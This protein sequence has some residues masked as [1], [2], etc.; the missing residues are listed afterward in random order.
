M[1]RSER[2]AHY[3]RIA[4][5]QRV[6]SQALRKRIYVFGSLRLALFLTV[7]AAAYMLYHTSWALFAALIVGAVLFAQLLSRQRKLSR[8]KS[9]ADALVKI[10]EN[11]LKAFN[12]DYSA[13]DGAAERV[14][15]AHDFSFDLDIFGE[16]SVFQLM[17]R[18]ALSMGKE[19]LADFLEHP[20]HESHPIA[21]RQEAVKELAELEDF[22]LDF[23]K[24]G[25]QTSGGFSRLQDVSDTFSAQAVF[26]NRIF[27]Q[28]AL[29]V[30]PLVYV[31][32]LIFSFIG[33]VPGNAFIILYFATLGLSS[34]PIKRISRIL[35]TFNKKTRR[36]ENYAQLYH[37]IENTSFRSDSLQKWQR[38][39]S[40]PM[41]ASKAIA[42]LDY[43]CRNLDVVF[44]PALFI[45]NPL[46]LFN[47]RYAL[48]ID[49][50]TR[51]H[52][53]QTRKWFDAL[54]EFDA[55]VSLGTF[56]A[57]NPDFAFPEISDHFVFIGKKM[58]HPLLSREKCVKNDIEIA[59]KPYFLIVTGANMAGKSTYLRTIGVNHLLASIGAP[60]YAE[61]LRFY[62]GR[63]LSNLRTADSLVNSE[64]YFFAEL[65]RLKMI[66]D[67][68]QSD[69]E[70]GLF[71][72]LDEILKGTNSED[73]QKGSF[74]LMRR[75]V[76]L[77]GNG[78]IATHDL[79]LGA[80]ETEFPQAI[81]NYH[82]D[83]GISNDTLSFTYL[84]HEGVARNMNA[85]FL[86]KN[87]GI[88]E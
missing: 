88:V 23:R 52:A 39:V 28:V 46:L 69:E 72:I 12:G 74:A 18:T 30:V 77:G 43:Y 5:E 35:N 51:R 42:K 83:A 68:L 53:D 32:L 40:Q 54:A 62:P 47:V 55:L 8:K 84:I 16:R 27:W 37:L 71:I 81:K 66:I 48:K 79:A 26:P 50:W 14:N 36:L 78:I 44:T 20:L 63:L 3:E 21:Q 75:F 38:T 13:F 87:M 2:I 6:L 86:M 1:T 56:T 17:N 73:K 59:R 41:P 45:L 11:E 61:S 15:A 33:N 64:S 25:S 24:I 19:Q 85:S 7:G 29:V 60:V 31:A 9:D 70:D 76:K 65:K 4:D 22:C 67:T 49:A 10:A 82:F 57:N 58:G 34:I 80:L